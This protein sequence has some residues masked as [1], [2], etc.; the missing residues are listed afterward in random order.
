[1]PASDSVTD[2][3]TRL[4]EAS[5]PRGEPHFIGIW[6]AAVIAAGLWLAHSASRFWN[7]SYT[8]FD[9]AFYVQCLW[10]VVHG[11]FTAYSTLLDMPML[12]NHADI[13]VLVLAPIF[14]IFPHP[15]M[16]VAAQ[17]IICALAAP[18]GY[19]TARF[20]GLEPGPS[21]FLALT[22]LLTPAMMHAA[23][24]E[25]HPEALTATFLMLMYH[26]QVRGRRWI[27]WSGALLTLSCKENMALLLAAYA[28]VH[29]AL[30]L[31]KLR[32]TGFTLSPML[33]QSILL[34]LLCVG[35]FVGY[36]KILRPALNQSNV[37]YGSLY[38]HLGGSLGAVALSPFT[39]PAALFKALNESLR[40]NLLWATLLPVAF[41][42]LLRPQWIII[43]GPILAQ[44]LLSNRS[45][46]WNV[47]HHYAA[48]LLPLWFAA[49]VEALLWLRAR[50]P[51]NEVPIRYL[52]LACAVLTVLTL[53]L[54]RTPQN[55]WALNK[56]GWVPG[57]LKVEDRHEMLKSV[58]PDDNV[59]IGPPY[60]SHVA[61]RDK[62]YS[63]QL[64]TKGSIT[65][66]I[67]PYIPP[68]DCN[69]LVI[70][71]LD[72][73]IFSLKASFFH[74]PLRY[75]DGTE[76]AASDAILHKL[77]RE[78]DWVTEQCVNE[79]SSYRRLKPGEPEPPNRFMP[80]TGD[81]KNRVPIVKGSVLHFAEPRQRELPRTGVLDIGLLWEFPEE[82]EIIPWM[83]L[84]LEPLV[85]VDD[86][87]GYPIVR[88]M[89]LPQGYNNGKLWRDIWR[90]DL[91]VWN[92]PP[93]R[94]RLVLGFED[95]SSVV[96]LHR[97]KQADPNSVTRADYEATIL[98]R[99][100]LG[101]VVLE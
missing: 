11:D 52:P 14:A 37:D 70:D 50:L 57:R 81:E 72:I 18:L 89:V 55:V 75:P 12:G 93:G 45:S 17:A 13:I 41:L 71:H 51:R 83:W 65:L 98:R 91:S 16:P 86:G 63:L 56:Y 20:S 101:E 54:V 87:K 33:V 26:G 24:F 9:L 96:A 100:P 32:R 99:I 84:R 80:I 82:R 21:F 28:I 66:G 2:S 48:P 43:A 15:L 67:T 77:L 61:K 35:W 97:R 38:D 4:A 95:E 78:G 5:P 68:T 90:A 7:F 10:K 64:L 47:D 19:R 79:W 34:L 1:M 94:Y 92:M 76:I 6:L 31:W 27:F 49:A 39:N 74:G 23:S 30:E 60:M 42:P 53:F 58:R 44:H 62:L 8:T 40:G 29:G 25:F 59:F 46:E 73:S 22:L 69:F 3:S 85:G 88:G 36:E